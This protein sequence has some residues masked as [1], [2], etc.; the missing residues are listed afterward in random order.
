[1]TETPIAAFVTFFAVVDPVG[2]SG[3]Y[4]QIWKTRHQRVCN[5]GYFLRA[6]LVYF[7]FTKGATA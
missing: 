4:G 3:G 7:R 1:M 5:Y 2:V 6:H